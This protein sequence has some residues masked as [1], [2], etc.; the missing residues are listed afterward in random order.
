M[1]RRTGVASGSGEGTCVRGVATRSGDDAPSCG[2]VPAAS[3]KTLNWI[4]TA[5]QERVVNALHRMMADRDGPETSPYYHFASLHGWPK[6]YCEHGQ[7]SFP[8]WH[9]AYLCEFE[10]AFQ[11]ADYDLNSAAIEAGSLSHLGWPCAR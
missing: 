10:R 2:G 5:E 7:E 8:G 9:R 4:S 1:S 6:H 11:Q 3:R